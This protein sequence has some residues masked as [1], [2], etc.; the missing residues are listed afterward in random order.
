MNNN[1]FKVCP[2]CQDSWATQEQFISDKLLELKGY[3]ADFEKLEYGLFYFV[4]NKSCCYTSMVVKVRDFMN[5]Y[6]GPFYTSRKTGGEECPGYCREK[7]QLKRCDAVCECAFVRE[8]IQIV[9][10]EKGS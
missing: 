1:V 7:E 2:C 6:P 4:H 10:D 9:K 8:I 5:L 3:Q